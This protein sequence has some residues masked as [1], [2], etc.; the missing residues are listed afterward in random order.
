[1]PKKKN[2]DADYSD[3]IQTATL[4]IGAIKDLPATE[5]FGVGPPTFDLAV[6]LGHVATHKLNFRFAPIT[7]METADDFVASCANDTYQE[8][9]CRML[10]LAA[11]PLPRMEVRDPFGSGT[12]A[13]QWDLLTVKLGPTSSIAERE[14]LKLIATLKSWRRLV[15]QIAKESAQ[16]ESLTVYLKPAAAMSR[17]S[18]L[19]GASDHNKKWQTNQW[20]KIRERCKW[21][22]HDPLHPG[23]IAEP[24]VEIVVAMLKE[25][26]PANGQ[27]TMAAVK[28][29]PQE[30]SHDE[31]M[32]RA[33][34]IRAANLARKAGK[35]S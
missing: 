2:H 25:I 31:I 24:H 17:L 3:F 19:H 13:Y 15:R 30:M 23:R 33:A 21:L 14:K 28:A 22:E 35:L 8:R 6:W 5:V 1:M 20:A 10:A 16:A 32:S 34:A 11:I 7:F 26:R 27:Y 9:E 4:L 18:R 29:L 12:S